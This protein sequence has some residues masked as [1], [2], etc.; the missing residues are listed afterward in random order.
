MSIYLKQRVYLTPN[1][2]EKIK[3]AFRNN[4]SCSLRIEPKVGNMDLMLT[5]SQINHLLHNKRQNKAADIILSKTQ[6]HKSGGFLPLIAAALPLITK[7][8]ASGALG[9]AGSKIAEK[10]IGKGIKQ[11]QRPKK[12]IQLK[13]KRGSGIYV[14]GKEPRRAI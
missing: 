6:L 8:A 14:I 11:K 3:S 13:L 1:Q 7:A 2:K 5:V 10:F 9:Y 12:V 4:Q